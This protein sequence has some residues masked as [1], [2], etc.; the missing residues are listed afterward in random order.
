MGDAGP[1]IAGRAC[2][3][4]GPTLV[5][6]SRVQSF[7]TVDV[8]TTDQW[9]V[10]ERILDFYRRRLEERPFTFAVLSAC[11]SKPSMTSASSR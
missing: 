7:V 4:S 5:V 10:P 11:H 9:L 2:D 8:M 6:T 3:D 1:N